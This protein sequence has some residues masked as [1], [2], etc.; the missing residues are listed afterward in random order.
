[1]RVTFMGDHLRVKLPDGST[2]RE[3]FLTSPLEAP[4]EAL[5]KVPEVTVA[6]P[7]LSRVEPSLPCTSCGESV[8]A[9]GRVRCRPCTT[10]ECLS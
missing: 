7:D 6:S 2:D 9:A 5:L 3:P 10:A 4:D 1:V 8:A